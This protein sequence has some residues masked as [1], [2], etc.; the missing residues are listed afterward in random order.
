V[1]F[2][3]I[4]LNHF[5]RPMLTREGKEFSEGTVRVLSATADTCVFFQVG[6]DIA[7]TMGSDR[8]VDTKAE[9]D[10]VGWV[11]LALVVSRTLTIFPLA[12]LIKAVRRAPLPWSH[13]VVLWFSAMRGA[14]A[15]AFALVFPG[16]NKDVLVDLTATV[17]LISVLFYATLM[18]RL[19]SALGLVEAAH[20][21]HGGAQGYAFVPTE[22]DDS[23][24]ETSALDRTTRGGGADAAAPPPAP[25]GAPPPD[26]PPEPD[27]RQ[28]MVAGARVFVPTPAGRRKAL[29]AAMVYINSFDTQ[30]R[31]L[32][33]GIV[34]VR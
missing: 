6:L 26:A 20:G 12:A 29:P 15:Y 28:V 7:L 17:V 16:K 3:A 8:G 4:S 22:A 31:W 21:A 19:V 30:L 10:M 9:G 27:F 25:A 1:L 24:E 13:V 33:S 23:D 18:R 5:V 34:R 14:G 32:V 11:V 2:A